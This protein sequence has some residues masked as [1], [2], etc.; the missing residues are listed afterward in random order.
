MGICELDEKLQKATQDAYL[1]VFDRTGI[2]VATI[3]VAIQVAIPFIK[4]IGDRKLDYVSLFVM[5]WLC[6]GL[7]QSYYMQH[8]NKF[9]VFN[10]SARAWQD[11]TVRIVANWFWVVM[12]ILSALTRDWHLSA[13]AFLQFFYF[14]YVLTWQ[15]RKREPPEKL[16][17]APQASS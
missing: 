12:C 2:Y 14:G 15:I 3:G 17:F 5:G 1:W 16:V 4:A 13:T 11:H 10:A 7:F 9:E 6:L 8:G